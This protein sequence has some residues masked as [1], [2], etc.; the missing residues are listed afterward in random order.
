MKYGKQLL[1][2]QYGPWQSKYVRYAK[3]KRLI[4]RFELEI[5]LEGKRN[6]ASS[7]V[8]LPLVSSRV[9]SPA[10]D[11]SPAYGVSPV[12]GAAGLKQQYDEKS[13]LLHLQGTPGRA[14]PVTNYGG[15]AQTHESR[16]RA[17]FEV[18]RL[19]GHF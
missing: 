11:S 7:A 9:G 6:R 16:R 18:R 15:E 5:G 8:D 14:T 13:S 17:F 3:L 1:V 4:T 19:T 12:G 2:G 10:Y